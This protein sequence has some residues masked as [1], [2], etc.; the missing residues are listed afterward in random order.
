M[1]G[2]GNSGKIVL[3]MMM[4]MM[5]VMMMVVSHEGSMDGLYGIVWNCLSFLSKVDV[6]S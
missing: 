6:L 2:H 3:M 5:I 4:M 1:F